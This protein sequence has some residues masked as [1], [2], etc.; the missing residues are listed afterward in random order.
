MLLSGPDSKKYQTVLQFKRSIRENPDMFSKSI[1]SKETANS[2]NRI[3]K[4]EYGEI[5][6]NQLKVKSINFSKEQITTIVNSYQAGISVGKIKE[7]FDCSE[8]AIR[9]VLKDRNVEIIK[10][11]AQSKLDVKVI[12]DMYHNMYSLNQIAKQ[13]GVSRHTVGKVLKNHG[14]ELR[15]RSDYN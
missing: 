9:K 15:K 8:F 3:D 4:D 13:F 10:C 2:K 7:R 12:A 14:V 6:A 5:A 11:P 1:I